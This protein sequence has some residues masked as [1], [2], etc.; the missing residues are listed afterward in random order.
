[1]T[2]SKQFEKVQQY[3]SMKLWSEERIRNAVR[4]EWI[5]E[6]EF[7]EITGRAFAE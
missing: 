3:Y 5:T 1:M 2:H 7:L 4:K 6:A